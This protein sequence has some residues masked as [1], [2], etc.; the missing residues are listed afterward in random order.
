MRTVSLRIRSGNR[1]R[2]NLACFLATLLCICNLSSAQPLRDKSPNASK[3]TTHKQPNADAQERFPIGFWYGPPASENKLETWQRIADAHFTLVGPCNEYSPADNR[4]MLQFCEQ[5]N[6]KALIV[7]DRIRS[8]MVSN[9]EW[10]KVV[11]H[12]VGD[13]QKYPALYGYYLHDEPSARWFPIL[14]E[15]HAEFRQSDPAHIPYINLFPNYAPPQSLGTPTY[16]EYLRRYVETVRPGVISYDHYPLLDSGLDRP[17]YFDN[18][19]AVRTVAETSKLPLWSIIQ[20]APHVPYRDPTADELRW[21]AYTSLAYGAKG[22]L[23]FTYWPP[24]SLTQSAIVDTTGQPTKR[25][26]MVQELN[27]QIAALGPTLLSL[28]S[29][30]VYHTGS[31][32]AGGTRLPAEAIL[33]MPAD[34]SL[35]VGG[36][37]DAA[38]NEYVMLVNRD[39]RQGQDFEVQLRPDV[40]AVSQFARVDGKRVEVAV[41]DQRFPMSLLPGEG[42]LFALQTRFADRGAFRPVTEIKFEFTDHDEDW[43]AEHALSPPMVEQGVM[44]SEITGADP[45]F[46]RTFLAIPPDRYR[47]LVVKMKSPG[48]TAALFWQTA[49]QPRFGEARLVQFPTVGD[50]KLHAY[51][52]D[53]KQHPGWKKQVI[54]AIR[55]DPTQEEDTKGQTVEI[56]FIRG[57]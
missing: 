46:S 30:A 9:T 43:A 11:R 40:V 57:E 53:L 54:R 17:D 26:G 20:I 48:R 3:S 22:L 15:I 35:L 19:E 1:L 56:D 41:K 39:Y 29:T 14:G 38:N 37:V 13:F 5:L 6:L 47:R 49:E 31:I 12:V 42:R 7:D 33:Q 45:Y 44:R 25:Y 36:F 27:R 21:Q 52:I 23:Y 51:V 24:P 8:D 16:R 4:A 55:L 34:K 18:L 10:R 2:V 32:P 50:D 28:K